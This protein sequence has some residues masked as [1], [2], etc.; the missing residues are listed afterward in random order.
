MGVLPEDCAETFHSPVRANDD[1]ALASCRAALEAQNSGAFDGEIAAL[2][3][4]TRQGSV[5]VSAE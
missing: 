5:T 4:K 3:L 1:Y 2:D